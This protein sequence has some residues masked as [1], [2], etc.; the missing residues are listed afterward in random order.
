MNA[1]LLT[2]IISVAAMLTGVS[3]GVAAALVSRR[4]SSGKVATSEAS[5]LW[6]QAQEM[7]AMLL[8]EKTKAE[9]QRDRFIASYTEQVLPMLTSINTLVQDLSGAVAD[10]LA[11]LTDN[12]AL[13]RGGGARVA[14]PEGQE[15]AGSRNSA[16]SRPGHD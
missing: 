6:A 15:P 16:G 5:V 9:E 3:G 8:A 1:A 7:R 2:V 11:L 10:A 4:S 12:S 13:L 14:A